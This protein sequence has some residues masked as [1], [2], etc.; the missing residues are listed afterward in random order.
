MAIHM[1]APNT[2]AAHALH[3]AS[4]SLAADEIYPIIH[5]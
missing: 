3:G 4:Q 2:D 1:E 5:G